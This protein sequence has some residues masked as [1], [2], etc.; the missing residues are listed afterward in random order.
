MVACTTRAAFAEIR[1]VANAGL[2][3]SDNAVRNHALRPET[4]YVLSEKRARYEAGGFLFFLPYGRG[5]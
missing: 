2:S 1:Q 5:R 4:E 3:R